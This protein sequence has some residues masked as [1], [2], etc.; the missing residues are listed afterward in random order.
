MTL[1]SHKKQTLT[2]AD[3]AGG[4]KTTT[5]LKQLKQQKHKIPKVQKKKLI[6]KSDKKTL[7]K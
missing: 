5:V 2:A 3:N 4:T 7:E 1:K 6:K